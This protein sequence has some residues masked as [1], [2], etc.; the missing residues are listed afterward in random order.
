MGL[1]HS[2][3]LSVLTGRRVCV[4]DS[5]ER[6]RSI[7]RLFAKKLCV[8]E[9]LDDLLKDDSLRAMYV[10][11]PV[12]THEALIKQ[13]VNTSG[14]DSAVFVEK[15][16]SVDYASA[17]RMVD[18]M[19]STGRKN[20]VGFQKRFNGVYKKLKETL[21]AGVIGDVSQYLAHS[22]SYDVPKR[23]EGWKFEPPSG[24]VTLDFGAHLLDILAFLFGEPDVTSSFVSSTFSTQVEDFAHA[25]L[26]HKEVYGTI[27]VGWTMRNY[28]PNDHA[29]E[30]HGTKGT[31][32]ATDDELTLYLD[33]SKGDVFAKGITK[34]HTSQLTPEVPYLLT[35]PEYVC[36]DQYFLG[37]IVDGKRSLPDFEQASRINQIVDDI[38]ERARR[39]I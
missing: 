14:G 2:A 3:I 17:K 34:Y 30:I 24:G 32:V 29:I 1:Q 16:L 9:N 35:Y 20:M 10:C 21:D 5:S 22:F 12:Q 19:A 39:S 27:E 15:P 8:H 13:I 26:A 33:N 11:T 36:E 37:S 31:A 7:A 25:A 6:L 28:A 4:Y 23:A 38:R 18:L